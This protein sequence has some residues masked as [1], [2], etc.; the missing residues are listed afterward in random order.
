M[1]LTKAQKKNRKKKE[2]RNE[3]IKKYKMNDLQTAPG[4]KQE[5]WVNNDEKHAKSENGGP[6][7][8]YEVE[9]TDHCETS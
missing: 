5:F 3:R 1:P 4:Q 9:T 6:D 7:Y 2:K 8:P